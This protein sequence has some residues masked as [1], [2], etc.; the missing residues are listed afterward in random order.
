VRRLLEATPAH[1]ALCLAVALNRTSDR[2]GS[3]TWTTLPNWVQ[4]IEDDTGLNANDAW[5]I[6]H[7]RKS[8]WTRAGQAFQWVSV[9]DD[10]G[11]SGVSEAFII[12]LNTFWYRTV[13]VFFY[14]VQLYQSTTQP[15]RRRVCL[16]VC[17]S[18]DGNS[19]K[20]ISVGSCSLHH[21]VARDSIVIDT[22]FHTLRLRVTLRTMASTET[23]VGIR[24]AKN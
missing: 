23:G 11:D 20:L 1:S 18:H 22:N 7:D 4:Q 12:L 16:H 13:I 2:S 10:W 15:Y 19:S 3:A 9:S 21:R 6:A 17:L 14:R 5:R 8:W 24:T